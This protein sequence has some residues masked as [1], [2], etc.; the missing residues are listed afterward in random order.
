MMYLGQ[1]ALEWLRKEEGQDLA[2]YGMQLG[3]IAL[4]VIA[5]VT[6]IGGSLFG[7]FDF[8]ASSAGGWMR[9]GTV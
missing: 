7:I 4:V 8:L 9:A 5:V 3:L 1:V 6:V 2:E